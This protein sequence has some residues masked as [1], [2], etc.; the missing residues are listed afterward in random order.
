MTDLRTGRALVPFPFGFDNRWAIVFFMA[1]WACVYTRRENHY[2]AKP[3][4]L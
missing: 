1:F 4:H 3:S 2:A